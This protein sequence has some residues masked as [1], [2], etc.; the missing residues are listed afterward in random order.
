MTV[1]RFQLA[2]VLVDVDMWYTDLDVI[3]VTF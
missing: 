3:Y 1:V 2:P